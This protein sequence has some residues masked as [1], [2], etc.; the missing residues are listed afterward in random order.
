MTTPKFTGPWVLT[1]NSARIEVRTSPDSSY[2][3]SHKDEANATLI[4]SAPDLYVAL[5]AALPVALDAEEQ[6]SNGEDCYSSA[7]AIIRAALAKAYGMKV[8]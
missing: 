2:A 3:F 5:E 1:R 6:W 4:A 8:E 7:V